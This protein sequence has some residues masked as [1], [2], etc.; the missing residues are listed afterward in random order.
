MALL[1]VLQPPG[2]IAEGFEVCDPHAVGQAQEE[3]ADGDR[4]VLDE[5][6]ALERAPAGRLGRTS[7]KRV[8]SSTFISYSANGIPR[9]TRLPP[10]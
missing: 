10:R 9:Q 7:L 6:A 4:A 1:H 3:V 5:A 8:A 2:R